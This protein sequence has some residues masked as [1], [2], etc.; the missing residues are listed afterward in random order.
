[1]AKVSEKTLLEKGKPDGVKSLVDVVTLNLSSMQIKDI[2]ASLFNQLSKVEDL[3]LSKNRILSFPSGV[4]LPALKKLDLSDN[5]ISQLKFLKNF[6]NLESLLLTANPLQENDKYLAVYLLPKLKELESINIS[7]TRAKI[8]S[9]ETEIA[10][11]IG[12]TWAQHFQEAYEAEENLVDGDIDVMYA[13]FIKIMKKQRIVAKGDEKYSK[14]HDEMLETKS[15][16]YFSRFRTDAEIVDRKKRRLEKEKKNGTDSA[17]NGAVK[18][19]GPKDKK[20]VNAGLPT[21]SDYEPVHFLR[22][23]SFNNDPADSKTKIWR[24][25]FQPSFKPSTDPAATSNGANGTED[26]RLSDS[27]LIT[28]CGGDSICLIDCSSGKVMKKYKH[29]KEDFYCVAWSTLQVMQADGEKRGET[30][31][32]IAAAGQQGDIKLLQ[33]D[34]LLCI[35]LLKGHK[36]HVNCLL[37]HTSNPCYLF[38]GSNDK[39]VML[40][41]IGVPVLPDFK[42]R[43][44]ALINFKVPV[45]GPCDVLNLH[46]HQEKYIM[47]A[48][49]SHLVVWDAT[50]EDANGS[51]RK[52]VGG[53]AGNKAA[54]GPKSK[55][56]LLEIEVPSKHTIHTVVDGLVGVNHSLVA[57]KYVQDGLISLWNLNDA[58]KSNEG[59]PVVSVDSITQLKWS[60]T[61]QLYINLNASSDGT[62]LLAG[63][64]AGGIWLYNLSEF[65]QWG[66]TVSPDP[67]SLYQPSRIIEWPEI[68]IKS[69]DMGD[70][71]DPAARKVIINHLAI[72]DDRLYIIACTDN[73]IVCIWKQCSDE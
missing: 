31:N 53:K 32:I 13:N 45:T 26:A 2:D 35:A 10:V 42:T 4:I 24:C 27:R 34:Q 59:R 21:C 43:W 9:L 51:Q 18:N 5:T 57:T 47:A 15:T 50:A 33:P 8:A 62:M 56:H 46:L 72:S 3:D 39:S 12:A 64:D 29:A 40:W 28:T 52:S 37:F 7:E 16:D 38:S 11:E 68:H 44:K 49:E 17:K 73:N 41:D 1:M 20:L 36:K 60:S 54:K 48:T 66:G 6:S 19:G 23:H 55:K 65:T 61:D 22:C 63:D 25:A 69:N 58:I 14:I 70:L 30:T 67:D 71:A